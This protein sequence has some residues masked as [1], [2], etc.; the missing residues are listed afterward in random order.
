MSCSEITAL[1]LTPTQPVLNSG[2]PLALSGQ[3]C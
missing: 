3:D 2:G 1:A